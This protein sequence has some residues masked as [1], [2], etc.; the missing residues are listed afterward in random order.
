MILAIDVDYR[1]S[2]AVAA[3]V[4]FRDW[5]A[6]A[7]IKEVTTNCD[8]V[9]DYVP[10]E[11]Y[12][13]ELP[14][15]LKLLEQVDLNLNTIVIDG[16]VYL[17]KERTPGLGRYLYDALDKQ[18]AVIGVAKTAFKDTPASTEVKRGT[19]QR[20]LYVTAAG[21]DEAS[22]QSCIQTMRG[23]DRIPMLLAR[24]HSKAKV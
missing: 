9:H 13:R 3:G 4:L 5:Q 15:L 22:A 18:I 17:G 10:G 2:K 12:R 19:S 7:P 1:Q 24:D 23:R 16:Y 11:F 14:C 21:T 20:P 8:L 6:E